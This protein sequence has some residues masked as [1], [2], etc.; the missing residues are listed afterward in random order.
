MIIGM[1]LFGSAARGD[2]STNS[3]TD[4]LCIKA[5]GKPDILKKGPMEIQFLPKEK[6]IKM[7]EDGDLF[8]LH[9][10]VEGKIIFDTDG[11]F[12]NFKEKLRVKNNYHA[13]IKAASDLGWY[14]LSFGQ[15]KRNT[16]L[17]N[18]RIAWCVRT[19]LISKLVE[20]GRFIFSP[21]GIA[22]NFPEKYISKL[23]DLRRSMDKG[24]ERFKNLG[25][26]MGLYGTQNP[27]IDDEDTYR[28]RF[29]KRNNYVAISTLDKL[30]TLETPEF[31]VAYL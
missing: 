9:L 10:A 30:A 31:T 4:V 6:L 15:N 25:K 12:S 8:A 29:N 27:R 2:G 28:D 3:D 19:I 17:V 13:E 1:M 7:A 21:K 26:F 23:I 5:A 24:D 14:L 20:D 22:Q 16:S 11:I 18:K